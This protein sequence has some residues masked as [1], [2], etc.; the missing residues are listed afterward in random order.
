M[1]II[2][3]GLGSLGKIPSLFPPTRGRARAGVKDAK[4][5]RHLR[6]LMTIFFK[7]KKKNSTPINLME[8]V[9]HEV[10]NNS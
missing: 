6:P 4:K 1:N 8:R 7:I 2:C 3:F 9:D 10:K 5:G